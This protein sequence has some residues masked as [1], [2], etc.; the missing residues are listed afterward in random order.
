MMLPSLGVS[1]SIGAAFNPTN[2]VYS[3]LGNLVA[4]IFE[5]GQLRQD[6]KKTQA[7][8]EQMLYAYQYTI[9]NSLREVSNALLEFNKQGEIVQSQQ[10]TMNAAQTAF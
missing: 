2:L 9:I 4:P 7:Q 1:G 3:A 8:K 6:V 5:G 10:A